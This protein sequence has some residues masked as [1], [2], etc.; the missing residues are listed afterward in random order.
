MRQKLLPL[1]GALLLA[2][3]AAGPARAKE[4]V[5]RIATLAPEGTSWFTGLQD[6]DKE[7][8]EK[9]KGELGLKLYPGGV[10][11]DEVTVLKKMKVGQLQGAGLTGM[12]LG[13]V[14]SWARVLELPFQYRTYADVD[15][16]RAQIADRLRADM[17]AHGYVVVGISEVGFG[18]VFSNRELRTVADMKNAKP[19]MWEGDQLAATTYQAFGV[20]PTPLALPDVI[21]SLETGLIDT[22]YCS[23]AACVGLQWFS[24]VKYMN[25][26]PLGDGTSMLLVAKTAFDKLTDDQKKIL[27]EVGKKHHDDLI[28]KIRKENDDALQTLKDRGI[29]IV[30]W[31]PK[32]RAT[33]ET[34]GRNVSKS[35]AGDGEGKLFP[36]ALFDEVTGMLDAA[37]AAQPA[38]PAPPAK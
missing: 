15:M 20:N 31:D 1:L 35:F 14:S 16:V 25:D 9:S 19:W 23:P 6:L 34:I 22:V 8:R 3:A 29:Q 38:P 11:G 36:Q 28:Q 7:L 30:P 32:E 13:Q 18:Y 10:A 24:K 27:L 26:V 17:E 21:T 2:A 33:F 37:H 12:G 4:V 5:L